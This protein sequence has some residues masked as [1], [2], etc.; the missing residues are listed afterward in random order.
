LEGEKFLERRE[1]AAEG[2]PVAFPRLDEIRQLAELR[3]AD[4]GL[5]VERLQIVAEMGVNVFVVVAFGQF[6]KL[7]AETLV[8][9]VV[10]AAGAP[11]IAAPIAEAF[12]QHFHFMSRRCSP[13]RLRRG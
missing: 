8:A 5:D 3:A 13:R 10:L 4:G 2:L 7:P 11:A 6:A 1:R 9:G 12:H